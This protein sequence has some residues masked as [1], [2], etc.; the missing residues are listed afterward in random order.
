MNAHES[1]VP[2]FIAEPKLDHILKMMMEEKHI[3]TYEMEAYGTKRE[4]GIEVAILYGLT[5]KQM[6]TAYFTQEA[7]ETEDPAI[8]K[9]FSETVE[10]CKESLIADYYKMIRL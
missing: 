9:F 10:K 4:D 7:V 8:S 1:G 2:L 3:H 5:D 6:V